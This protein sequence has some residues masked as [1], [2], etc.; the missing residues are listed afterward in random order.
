MWEEREYFTGLQ[1]EIDHNGICDI[2]P[3][4]SEI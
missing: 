3:V 2:L 4:Y 1:V